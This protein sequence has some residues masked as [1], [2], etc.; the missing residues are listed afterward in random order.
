LRRDQGPVRTL[1]ALRTFPKSAD[2]APAA[3]RWTACL[4]AGV[5]AGTL[6]LSP[7]F[8]QSVQE[9]H[10][11]SSAAIQKLGLQLDLPL[12]SETPWRIGLPPVLLAAAL[13]L[14]VAVLAYLL[15]DI[16]P[17]WKLSRGRR[18]KAETDQGN[19]HVPSAVGTIRAADALAEQGRFV[20]AMHVLLLQSLAEIRE[21]LGER[22]ADSLTSR[23]IL[24]SISISERAR[25]SLRQII[26]QVE[27][28]Y[29]GGR[30]AGFA[31]YVACREN[32]NNLT[33]ALP[34]DVAA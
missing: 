6:C 19:D 26:A 13:L 30:A 20:E 25:I 7:V 12:S 16:V 21:H 34:A 14:V 1:P 22:F 3:A 32:F 5:C 33:R 10:N 15:R 9:I 23:E 17:I 27:W 24:R 18:W 29:F 2:A 11:A 28:T 8:A 4:A 31:E